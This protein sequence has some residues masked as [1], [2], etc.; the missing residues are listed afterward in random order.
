MNNRNTDN[1]NEPA[2]AG[3]SPSPAKDYAML[4]NQFNSLVGLVNTLEKTQSMLNKEL[5]KQKA[6]VKFLQQILDE[7][8][9]VVQGIDGP[10]WYGDMCF[11]SL[12]DLW[13]DVLGI[14]F[15]NYL[16]TT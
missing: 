8:A 7:I 5:H 2:P 4:L 3:F 1:I 11:G 13:N 6:E 14:E 12:E 9:E 15:V 16:R 10:V